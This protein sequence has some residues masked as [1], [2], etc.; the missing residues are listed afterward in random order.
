[1]K[2]YLNYDKAILFDLD[3]TLVDNVSL[4]TES[5]NIAMIKNNLPY[6]FSDED[7]TKHM[8]LTPTESSLLAFKDVSLNQGLKYFSLCLK[9]EIEYLKTHGGKLYPL[10]RR[11]LDTLSSYF[12]LFIVS[13]SD[14]GYIENF[15]NIFHFQ[16]Y[17][18]DHLCAGDTSKD[19]FKNIL[20]IKDK[21]NIKDVTYIGDTL[22]D[23]KE[24]SKAKVHFIHAR[25]GF[26]DI[27]ENVDYIESL[28]DL[29]VR[30]EDINLGKEKNI[31]KK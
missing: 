2:S 22:K 29:L 3:G 28:S 9:E 5:W 16:N 4:I 15:I 19:K 18:V 8:G 17:F 21:Y 24:A 13:N 6:R 25:Y 14:K 1:M 12:P 10:E 27:I 11:V 7:L 20:I 23:Y 31:W 30:L 26:G